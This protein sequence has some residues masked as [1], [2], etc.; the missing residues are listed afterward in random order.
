MAVLYDFM[1]GCRYGYAW[2]DTRLRRI[3]LYAQAYQCMM[4]GLILAPAVRILLGL[5][6]AGLYPGVVFYLSWLA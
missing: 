6:E 1:L 3:A 2:R 4:R 5:F